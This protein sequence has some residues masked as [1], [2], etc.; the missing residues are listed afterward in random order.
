MPTRRLQLVQPP[1]PPPPGAALP[2]E[3]GGPARRAAPAPPP[4]LPA[5]DPRWVLAA[6]VSESLEG[7]VLP[8]DRRER[9]IRTGRVM[10][11][12]TFEAN[13]VIAIVQDQARRGVAPEARLAAS[14]P[15][16]A[17]VPRSAAAPDPRRPLR[18][19][20]ITAAI[21]TVE[22]VLLLWLI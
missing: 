6:R 14:S 10:G 22:I 20:V 19:A 17:I 11:L 5:T 18:I 16:L 1:P 13:L 8:P 4:T 12:S 3:E 15:Q 7:D 2:V 21:L 9:L